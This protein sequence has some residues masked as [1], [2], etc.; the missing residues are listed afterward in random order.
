MRGCGIV[1][2][3]GAG[4]LEGR[5]SCDA[6]GAERAAARFPMVG[7]LIDAHVESGYIA[8]MIPPFTDTGVLPPGVHRATVDEVRV[9]FGRSSELR[10][11]QMQSV[12]WMLD[13][14]RRAGITRIVLN[15]SFTTDILEPNDVDCVLLVD[16]PSLN[17]TSALE[18]L[19]AGLPF[20]DVSIAEQPDFD[21][22]V[23][24]FFLRDRDQQFKGMIEVIQWH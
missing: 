12:E 2:S 9:R 6:A 1:A 23:E 3:R 4:D 5:R 17:A 14:A 7:I 13:L 16:S 22:F 11:V 8:L 15:G 20:L 19:H 10:R 24:Q 21:Y 18:E